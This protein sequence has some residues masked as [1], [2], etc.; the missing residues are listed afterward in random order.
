MMMAS[1]SSSETRTAV[2]PEALRALT[3]MSLER[4]SSFFCSSPWTLVSPARPTLEMGPISQ[5]DRVVE[6]GNVQIDQSGLPDISSDKLGG[7]RNGGKEHGEVAGGRI[8]Q[9]QAV[10]EDMAEMRVLSRTEGGREEDSPGEGDDVGGNS[11]RGHGRER[12]EKGECAS[13]S[14]LTCFWIL[15]F[16]CNH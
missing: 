10:I 16:T 2:L 9:A 15:S 12:E 13:T 1:S 7:E 6:G 5:R 8:A 11:F 14:A 4:T 3:M